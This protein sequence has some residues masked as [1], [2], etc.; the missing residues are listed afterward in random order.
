[1]Q[2]NRWAEH[3]EVGRNG[4]AW[5]VVLRE[6]IGTAEKRCRLPQQLARV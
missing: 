1:M 3:V 5:E 4:V 2:A 6:A